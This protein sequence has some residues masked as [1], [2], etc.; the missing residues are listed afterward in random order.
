NLITICLSIV[1]LPDMENRFCNL[2]E[3]SSHSP[4]STC[5]Y[6]LYIRFHYTTSTTDPGP[7][8]WRCLSASG[9]SGFSANWRCIKPRLQIAPPSTPS[10]SDI[11][12]HD[13][14]CLFRFKKSK[15][16]PRCP[17]E[18]QFVGASSAYSLFFA[19]CPNNY[20]RTFELTSLIEVQSTTE[21]ETIKIGQRPYFVII[22]I[23]RKYYRPRS[24]R[25]EV[26]ESG[27][28]PA[29]GNSTL[30]FACPSALRVSGLSE[31]GRW[32][33]PCLRKTPPSTQ[34]QISRDNSLLW[35]P[36]KISK[37]LCGDRLSM[38]SD[39]A[40]LKSKTKEIV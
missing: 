10:A 28:P 11:S 25:V 8:A 32:T 3:I 17:L 21:L 24:H 35:Y 40:K 1:I 38:S 4:G 5:I 34:L 20:Y 31:N 22:S 27:D 9:A 29:N 12:R 26:A 33:R 37:S 6:I 23:F 16:S 2:T 39:S 7:T 36:V 19:S 30:K 13:R 14:S 18:P 15:R